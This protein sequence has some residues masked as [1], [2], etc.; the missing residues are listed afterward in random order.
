MM[1]R[2]VAMTERA[3]EGAE[4]TEHELDAPALDAQPATVEVHA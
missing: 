4:S 1:S 3:S 2:E